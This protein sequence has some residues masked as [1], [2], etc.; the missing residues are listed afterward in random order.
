MVYSSFKHYASRIVIAAISA[1]LCAGAVQAQTA[2]PSES[3]GES[4][5]NQ[6][7]TIVVTAQ[8]REENLQDVPAQVSAFSADQIVDAGINSTQDFVDLVPNVALDD[9][10]TYLNT[11]VV[12]RGVTQ[13]NNADSPIAVVVD[14]VPQNNQ[15]QLNMNLF[16]IERIEVL[17][18][19]Q[20]GLYGRNA[21]GGVI[22]IVTRE[23]GYEFGGQV[24][25]SYGSG[26]RVNF[27]GSLDIPV[28]EHAGLRVAGNYLT[29]NGQIDNS[30]T[31]ENVDFIDHDWELR[32]RGAV[33]ISENVSLDTRV[34]YR[35]FRAGA[36]Y[37]TVVFSGRADDILDPFSNIEG[38]T[39]GNIFDASISLDFDLGGVTLTSISAFTDITENYRGDLD[40]SNPV[41]SP[42]GF[43]GLGFQAGQGQDL[44]V[45][46]YSQEL[47]L[48]SDSAQ[49]FRWIAGAFYLHTNRSLLTRAF[50]DLDGSRAQIDD[51]ALRIV[52]LSEDNSNDAYA[53]YVNLDYDITDELTL[54]ASLRYDRDEREQTDLL[55]GNVRETS[56][57]S[58]QPK[59]TLTYN[60][61]GDHLIYA[62]Y[63]TG[64]RSG[65]F[66]APT[67]SIP[68]YQAEELENFE[69]GFKTSWANNRFILN[70]AIY[71]ANSDDFQFFFI[72][73]ATAS[74]IIGNIDDVA[75]W[76][77]ELEAQA[78]VAPGLQLFGSLG[79]TDT[80]IRRNTTDPTTVGN[81]TPK[82]TTW[83][84]NL[85]FQYE[86]ALS[87]Q[88]DLVLRSDYEHRG[89][90]FWQVDNVDVQPPVD[91]VDVRVAVES[92][93]FSV[94]LVGENIFGEGFYTDF[95][96]SA[97]SGFANPIAF[98][99][100]PARWT[101]EARLRF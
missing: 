69:A 71:R 72:D 60:F 97:F 40:F 14:G 81:R 100:P 78:L 13:I 48:V 11:F 24:S 54:S 20:G 65:G 63:S 91:I 76:G 5:N 41:T 80:D 15:K 43:L 73:A 42:G 21:I 36:V 74:Q 99:A 16:D 12:V 59:A 45:E 27:M 75:I 46:L 8:R 22:N 53:A 31:G 30:F 94:A 79:T 1:N 86:T 57:D 64:F 70:G 90:R 3:Q 61:T 25:G 26:D 47:R 2:E 98:R 56:F 44:D 96:P 35:D 10:F 55:T 77:V 19:P 33:D 28:S 29:S 37:D 87:D 58:W 83:S 38:V 93:S 82:N 6:L 88:L 66:N 51:P 7:N 23:P 52:E 34:S 84:A 67:V 101:I 95:N 17:R 89:R 85:G 92:Q 9:S 50:I 4:A 49:P 32:A 18:G 68:V 62:T 39:F